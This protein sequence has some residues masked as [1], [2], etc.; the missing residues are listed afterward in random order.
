MLLF[1]YTFLNHCKCL[2]FTLSCKFF[3][4]SLFYKNNVII[5]ALDKTLMKIKS[6]SFQTFRYPK[7]SSYYFL[8]DS[9]IFITRATKKFYLIDPYFFWVWRDLYVMFDSIVIFLTYAGN[10]FPHSRFAVVF[11]SKNLAVKCNLPHL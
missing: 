1:L 7:L 11:Q 2:L 3:I 10:F 5:F 8:E 9:F 4:W 6:Y